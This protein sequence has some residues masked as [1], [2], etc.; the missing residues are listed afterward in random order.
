MYENEGIICN[1]KSLDSFKTV[2]CPI[3]CTS[4][5]TKSH[6]TDEFDLQISFFE[7]KF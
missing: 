5:G 4:N 2:S 1:L 3:L 7:V 6:V